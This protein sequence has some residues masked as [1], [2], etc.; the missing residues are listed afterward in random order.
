[1]GDFGFN[2]LVDLLSEASAFG[3]IIYDFCVFA[4]FFESFSVPSFHRSSQLA[5]V[6]MRTLPKGRQTQLDETEVVERLNESLAEEKADDEKLLGAI[7][8]ICHCLVN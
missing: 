1:L 4:E 7:A 6:W 2:D 5:A 8:R 3:R